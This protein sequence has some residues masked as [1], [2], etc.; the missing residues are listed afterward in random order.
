MRSSRVAAVRPSRS[1]T[2][3]RLRATS[4]RDAGAMTRRSRLRSTSRSHDRPFHV[5]GIALRNNIRHRIG[6]MRR[7]LAVLAVSGAIGATLG[8][9]PSALVAQGTGRVAGTVTD[10]QGQPVAGAQVQIVGTTT[11]AAS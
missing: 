10:Q 2:S 11:G 9:A 4:D 6:T 3:A 7:L 5:E 1:R 8:L